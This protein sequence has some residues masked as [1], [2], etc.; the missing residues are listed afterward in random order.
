[1]VDHRAF[2][3]SR[4]DDY[5]RLVSAEDADGTLGPAL[6]GLLSLDGAEVLEVGA[7]TGRLT[8][9][10]LDRGARVV[11]CEPAAPMRARA[12]AHPRLEMRAVAVEDLVVEPGRF[13]L[14]IAGWVLGHFVSWHAPRGLEVIGAALDRMSAAVRP[15]GVVAVIETLGTGSTEPRA[16][17]AGL[18]AYYAW[19]ERDRGFARAVLATDYAFPDVETA[20]G[21]TGAF[22]GPDF[23]ARVRR[24]GWARVPE[25]T[26][27]WSLRVRSSVVAR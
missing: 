20:A 11:A 17:D 27:L 6:D 2:Y 12:P 10:L 14:A 9:L 5:E 23:A 16:P 3:E 18:A 24:E 7:G 22:F 26:G 19:L 4:A 21:V 25:R 15:G 1:M 8:R 13:D